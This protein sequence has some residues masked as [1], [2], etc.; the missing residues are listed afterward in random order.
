MKTVANV[1][2]VDEHAVAE[3]VGIT[4]R[5]VLELRRKGILTG[6]KVSR[7]TLRFNL[8]ECLEALK[9]RSEGDCCDDE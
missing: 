5:V 6:Y 2:L 7:S 4:P 3:A 1:K 9:R 8:A